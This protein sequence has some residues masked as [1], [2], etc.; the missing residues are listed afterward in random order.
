MVFEVTLPRQP[1]AN[2][3]RSEG[4]DVNENAKRLQ[5]LYEKTPKEYIDELKRL[6]EKGYQFRLTEGKVF[7]LFPS[8][9]MRKVPIKLQVREG[10]ITWYFVAPH[11]ETHQEFRDQVYRS[12]ALGHL[13]VKRACEK[14]LRGTNSLHVKKMH[15]SV[16]ESLMNHN[17]YR[18]DKGLDVNPDDLREHLMGFV[19]AEDKLK[20]FVQ[21]EN[22]KQIEKFLTKEEAEE[23]LKQYERH[24]TKINYVGPAKTTFTAGGTLKLPKRDKSILTQYKEAIYAK[25]TSKDWKEW[26]KYKHLEQPCRTIFPGKTVKELTEQELDELVRT[27][28]KGMRGIRS[29]AA[30]A[31]QPEGEFAE[32]LDLPVR[33]QKVAMQDF[34]E[35]LKT[36]SEAPEIKKEEKAK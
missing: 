31:R 30:Q 4:A 10:V 5:D 24:W 7:Q 22:G 25:F 34:I 16:K 18:L 11:D 27:A 6:N 17:H 1:D 21:D 3:W 32:G 20:L 29:E 2:F 23:I 14:Y 35:P 36:G 8:D 28:E 33:K 19:E 9:E 12:A 15:T 26:N 13:R